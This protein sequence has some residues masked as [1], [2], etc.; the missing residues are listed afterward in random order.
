MLVTLDTTRADHL[1]SYGYAR[2]HTPILDEIAS[3]GVRFDSAYTT[4]PLTTPAHASILTGL[5]PAR[6]GIHT[7][8]DAT[9][10][11]LA[12]TLPEVLSET[13]YRTAAS[14][15]AF[16][17]TRMWNLD[18]GFD[19]YFD[20]VGRAGRQARWS[21]ERPADA[22]TDDLLGWMNDLDD[23][24]FFVWA[25]YY[26]PHEPH[27]AEAPWPPG[28]V[29]AYDA[30]I[31]EVDVAVGRL[32]EGARAAAGDAGVVVVVVGDHGEA[33]K[34]EHGEF[35]HGLY[36]FE[37]TARVPF[38]IAGPTP[39]PG[40][41]EEE[42][43]S[44]VDVLPT[45]LGWLGLPAIDGVDGVD[46]SSARH[47][48][49][50]ERAPVVIESNTASMRFGW[51]PEVAVIDERDKFFA[52]PSPRLYD[53]ALDPEETH[54]RLSEPGD[55]E[56]DRRVAELQA[57]AD[58]VRSYP[59][60]GASDSVVGDAAVEAQLAALG[61]LTGHVEGVGSDVDAKDRGEIIAKLNQARLLE[62]ARRFGDARVVYE[63]VLLEEPM[64]AEA[65]LG[66]AKVLGGLGH[67]ESALLVLSDA[68]AVQPDSTILRSSR[69]RT[70][71][72]LGRFAE[73]EAD[74]RRVLELVPEDEQARTT[75]LKALAGQ[76]PSRARSQ[77]ATWRINGDDAAMLDAFEGQLALQEGDLEAAETYLEQARATLM[78]PLGVH[79]GLAAIATA[80]GEIPLAGWHLSEEVARFPDERDAR[81]TLGDFL[82]AQQEWAAAAFEYG[83]LVAMAGDDHDARRAWAQA[84]FND[85]RVDEAERILAPALATSHPLILTLQANIL[86]ALGRPDE[87]RATF[88][89]A[90]ARA[91]AR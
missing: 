55:S 26:D 19:E 3:Q 41:V 72:S 60:I 18:Q 63:A 21:L 2:A 12:L 77:I 28:V 67:R 51:H 31:A 64:L 35:T 24:P 90:K 73:A 76:H 91:N 34:G 46:L 56:R 65:R 6:H 11:D 66:L 58:E 9:L 79:A 62:N 61:Y 80:R 37:P 89:R 50:P 70:A 22:V 54:D 32:L 74:A 86:A 44:V 7:N 87:A 42:T 48:P 25:H 68:L 45:T 10:P 69:A 78:P 17:T 8:G 27:E 71:L 82:M 59:V 75:L 33:L 52:T 49:L 57:V 81:R 29:D 40:R 16:V 14:V 13:G 23:G 47:A 84:V 43:V 38:L 1:G 85:G 36:V 15:G 83:Q 39:G 53:L 20:A 5:Y 30:E 88:Q 4:V